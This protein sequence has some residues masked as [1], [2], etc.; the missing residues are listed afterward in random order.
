M[1]PTT[2][3]T[4]WYALL[5]AVWVLYFVLGGIDLGVGQLLRRTDRA[6]A[7]RAIGPT[8]AANDVWLVIAVAIT[9]GAFPGWY[10]E[11]MSGAYL[12]L[13]AVVA[14]VMVRHGG[15]ELIG[16]AT[17]RAQARWERVIVG[18]SLAIPF[19]WGVIWAGAFDGSLAAGGDAG[20]GIFTPTGIVAGLALTAL[21][22]LQGLAFLRL[23]VPGVRDRLSAR[24]VSVPAVALLLAALVVFATQAPSG[25]ALGPVGLGLGVLCATGLAVVVRAA[26]L[27]RDLPTLLGACAAMTG[28]FGALFA[29]LFR[30]PIAGSGPHSVALS[31][32]ASGATTL[33]AMLAISVVLLPLGLAALGYAYVRFLRP[34]ADAPRGGVG[35]LVAR[36]AR[37]TL[38]ELR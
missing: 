37:G 18:T 14:A 16:H 2:L 3:E 22:R 28:A 1:E 5:G 21:C 11:F 23:R 24:A 35:G 15:I 30:T 26:A 25:L 29:V 31:E 8:W 7:L 32:A 17:P 4:T 27:G 38:R 34:P 13:V 6:T 33:G 9:L 10:A 19:L 36:A 20:L 12:P